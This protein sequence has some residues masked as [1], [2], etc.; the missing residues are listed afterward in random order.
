MLTELLQDK[1]WLIN[2]EYQE[3]Q[4]FKHINKLRTASFVIPVGNSEVIPPGTLNA[5][6]QVAHARR[7]TQSW[8]SYL[9]NT[10]HINV[11]LEKQNDGL[12]GRVEIP[13]LLIVT[14]GCSSDCVTNVLK[15]LLMEYVLEEAFQHSSTVASLPFLHLYDTTA[16]WNLV[17]QLKA[18]H[19]SEQIGIDME[20]IGQFM[21]GNTHPCAE[22][23]SRLEKSI[24]DLGRQ[25]MEVS[26]R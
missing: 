2:I 15:A 25:L 10:K 17:K 24:Q 4:L 12:W 3:H 14:R 20:L 21:T 19:I 23:A 5:L 1:G 9:K 13:G 16:V 8:T 26:I 18:S 11:I 22:T 6:L 7:E